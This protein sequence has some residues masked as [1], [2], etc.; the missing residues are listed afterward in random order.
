MAELAMLERQ[1]LQ[2]FIGNSTAAFFA[3]LGQ[4]LF[5]IAKEVQPSKTVADRIDLLAVDKEGNAVVIELKRGSQKLHLLQAI[6]YAAM[7]AH[8]APEELRAL[9]DPDKAEDLADFLEVDPEDLNRN[10]RIILLAEE[11]EFEVLVSA[12]WLNERFGVD[13]TCSRITLAKDPRTSDEYITCNIV[14]PAPELAAQARSRS[15]R[16]VEPQEPR[17]NDWDEALSVLDN[18]PLVAFFKAELAKGAESYL[19]KRI[20]RY[21]VH[22]KRRWFV[23]ARR[24]LAYVWQH[25][26]FEN[27]EEFWRQ[28]V[29][30]P[31]TVVPV[32][33]ETCLR[34]RLTS[35]KDFDSFCDAAANQLLG[36]KWREPSE[37]GEDDTLGE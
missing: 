9:C 1:H 2:E 8:R 28:R 26:R 14:Y 23:A 16:K 15:T 21:R 30:D 3:E 31:T 22:G 10:Q 35:Q 25:G 27:D 17:W 33:E 7:M 5:L 37:E 19:P 6:S 13:V 32:K 29:E 36:A 18:G 24:K 11:F 20:L 12:E 34:F 4:E